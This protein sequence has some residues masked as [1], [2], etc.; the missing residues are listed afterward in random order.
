M[1]KVPFVKFPKTSK[2]QIKL[3]PCWC[4]NPH[5]S[6]LF[7]T[8]ECKQCGFKTSVSFR[9]QKGGKSYRYEWNKR[10]LAKLW[11]ENKDKFNELYK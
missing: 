1:D 9:S 4:G 5:P 11:K 10:V 6:V 2:N 8:V 7:N 3:L